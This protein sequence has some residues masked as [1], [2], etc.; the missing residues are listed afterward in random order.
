MGS[1]LFFMGQSRNHE[2]GYGWEF[3]DFREKHML[4][5]G[6]SG[7]GKTRWL[8]QLVSYLVDQDAAVFALDFKGDLVRLV[9]RHVTRRYL[10]RRTV[11]CDPGGGLENGSRV[12]NLN[13]FDG[14]YHAACKAAH[15]KT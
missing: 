7:A 15:F 4:L 12:P 1:K 6:Q 2:R 14:P 13:I 11:F 3:S 9:S 10:G 8:A 5:V